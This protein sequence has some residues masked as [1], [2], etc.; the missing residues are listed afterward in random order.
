M[1]FYHKRH[2]NCQKSKLKVPK[3]V[4]FYLVNHKSPNVLLLAVLMLLEI[5]HHTEPHL[6]GLNDG[7]EP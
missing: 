2:Q 6:K 5:K 1:M 4:S 3:K 7:V